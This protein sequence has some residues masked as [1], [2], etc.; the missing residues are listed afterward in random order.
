MIS[1]GCLNCFTQFSKQN[2]LHL[3]ALC[4]SN[5]IKILNGYLSFRK[6]EHH[7]LFF[8]YSR[9]CSSVLSPAGVLCVPL[10]TYSAC[11]NIK[12]RQFTDDQ[13]RPAMLLSS[14]ILQN[15]SFFISSLG[16]SFTYSVGVLPFP[17][18]W[19]IVINFHYKQ[20]LLKISYTENNL[21]M[22]S[23]VKW[24]TTLP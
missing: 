13:I 10:C 1:G 24:E 16:L 19:H 22:M 4:A 20:I 8:A 17:I 2:I 15:F 9:M 5:W 14:L 23:A 12:C 6:F 7:F 21:T 3:W 18:S 11:T